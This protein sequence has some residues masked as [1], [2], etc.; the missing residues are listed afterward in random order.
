MTLVY[1]RAI[2]CLQINVW[3]YRKVWPEEIEAVQE[4]AAGFEDR[5]QI[6]EGL[7]ADLVIVDRK[8]N[9]KKVILDGELV[10]E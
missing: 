10:R 5:G 7:R 8:M 9:V 1:L 3:K 4:R 6:L 2:H